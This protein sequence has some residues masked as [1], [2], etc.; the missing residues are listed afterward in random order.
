MEELLV[1]YNLDTKTKFFFIERVHKS[2]FKRNDLEPVLKEMQPIW[3]VETVTITHGDFVCFIQ[4]ALID[5][6]G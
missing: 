5:C 2:S 3:V 4:T 1:R 6:E